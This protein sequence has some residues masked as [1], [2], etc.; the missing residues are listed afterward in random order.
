[1]TA[2]AIIFRVHGEPIP[3]GSMRAF[4]AGG[5]AKVRPDNKRCNPWRSDVAAVAART[6]DG[7][8]LLEGPVA[9]EMA[10]A[11][12]RPEKVPKARRGR[13]AAKPDMDKLA[14]AVLDAL[15]GVVFTDDAQVCELA[16]RK[17]YREPSRGPGVVV[18]VRELDWP[19]ALEVT[20]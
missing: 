2:R 14:R 12:P 15:T 9:I 6:M 11:L 3:Q 1:M 19:H 20:S 8:P 16:A 13:P 5:R 18:E 4:V 10:F 17:M 7:A